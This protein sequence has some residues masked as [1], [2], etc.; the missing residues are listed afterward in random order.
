[1]DAHPVVVAEYGTGAEVVG[2]ARTQ[3]GTA[4]LVVVG[5]TRVVG[6]EVCDGQVI[7]E[8]TFRDMSTGAAW[9]D[10]LR[11]TFPQGDAIIGCGSCGRV[12]DDS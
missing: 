3:D 8:V 12:G 7:A 10:A 9:L 2:D 4:V 5:G 6:A 1:M 11:E